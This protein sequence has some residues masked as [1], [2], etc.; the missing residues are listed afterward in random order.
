MHS[1]QFQDCVDINYYCIHL[2][3]KSS[4]KGKKEKKNTLDFDLCE[5][6]H[7]KFLSTYQA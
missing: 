6:F 7:C 2:G 4:T 5:V 3:E 1:S